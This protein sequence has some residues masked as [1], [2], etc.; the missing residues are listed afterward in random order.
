MGPNLIPEVRRPK[1]EAWNPTG[2][3]AAHELEDGCVTPG[4]HTLLRFDMVVKN[5]GD[6]DFLIPRYADRPELFEWSAAHHHLH[7]KKFNKYNLYDANGN[8]LTPSKKAGFCVEDLE[9]LPGFT[10]LRNHPTCDRDKPMGIS[11]GWADVYDRDLACQFLVIDGLPDADYALVAITNEGRLFFEDNYDDNSTCK[12]L[13]FKTDGAGKRIVEELPN[14]P[15]RADLKTA[16]VNFNDIPEGETAVRPVEFEVRSCGAA[17]FKITDGPTRL[18]GPADTAFGQIDT[19]GSHL[20]EDHSMFPRNAFLWL[21]YKGTKAGDTA[22]GTV[23]VA[24]QE[25]GQTW[26]VPIIANTIRRPT[27]AVVLILDQSGSMAWPA[28]TGANRIDVLHDAASRFVELADSTDAIGLVRF[29]HKAY[30]IDNVL[31]LSSS[32]NVTK[33]VKDVKDTK[34]IGAT[35]IGNGLELARTI[36][37]P[38][39]GY[40]S[41]AMVVFTDGLENTSKFISEVEGLITDKTFA[42]GLGTA[43]QVSEPALTKL[44]KGTGGYLLV[45]GALSMSVDDYFRLSKYFLQILAAVMNKDIVKDP[46]GFIYAG[47]KVRIPFTLTLSDIEAT[48]ILM[49]DRPIVRMVLETPA[50]H[51]LGPDEALSMGATVG[52]GTNMLYYR[53]GLPLVDAHGGMPPAHAGIWHAVLTIEEEFVLENIGRQRGARYNVSVHGRSNVRMVASLTQ[54]SFEPGASLFVRAT[55]TEF[56][57]PLPASKAKV[58]MEVRAPDGNMSTVMLAEGDAGIFSATLI[59]SLDGVYQCRVLANGWTNHGDQ[60]TREQLLT[61]ATM[62]GGNQPSP[63]SPPPDHS[64]DLVCSLLNC[65]LHDKSVCQFLAQHSIDANSL[66]HCVRT[67]CEARHAPPSDRELAEREGVVFPH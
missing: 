56:G 64:G 47:Q 57:V 58:H 5:V 27:V 65:F 9:Q 53:F 42:V 15:I 8:F 40:D 48:V 54:N 34:P 44:T 26:I 43:Q 22:T 50:G 16:T 59:A 67:S 52:F 37:D 46:S 4:D 55:L 25:T 36:I 28:G 17:H 39:T 3:D 13:R 18:T 62:H 29:D 38:V 19:P 14:P 30:L 11:S 51:V 66:Q 21:T 45:S 23:T 2:P 49:T 31:S 33:L 60:F 1:I 7:L 35:S 12:G 61:G 10:T 32:T 6:A 63:T 41:K 24:C 20:D